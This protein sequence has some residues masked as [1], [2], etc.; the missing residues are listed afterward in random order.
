MDKCNQP[1]QIS[2]N[3]SNQPLT[4]INYL[5][6]NYFPLQ[7]NQQTVSNNQQQIAQ[8][9]KP[10]QILFQQN[11][12]KT[13][14]QQQ[15]TKMTKISTGIKRRPQ[16]YYGVSDRHD[17]SETIIKKVKFNDSGYN[18]IKPTDDA[19]I[20]NDQNGK[21]YLHMR[22]INQC[23]N[24]SMTP[25]ELIKS[26]VE[27]AAKLHTNSR[28][29]IR[30]SL[31]A[32]FNNLKPI[33][34]NIGLQFDNAKKLWQHFEQEYFKF[35]A[36]YKIKGYKSS[37]RSTEL[38]N[39]LIEKLKEYSEQ[40]PEI[41]DSILSFSINNLS[42]DESQYL[43]TQL[44]IKLGIY[45]I[46]IINQYKNGGQ[47]SKNN[48]L[49]ILIS[50]ATKNPKLIDAISQELLFTLK[51][52][53]GVKL[54]KEFKQIIYNNLLHDYIKDKDRA[55]IVELIN[56]THIKQIYFEL[57]QYESII[58]ICINDNR[59][60]DAIGIFNTIPKQCKTFELYNTILSNCNKLDRLD[61]NTIELL[62][63]MVEYVKK[64]DKDPRKYHKLKMPI[65]EICQ[66]N[67]QNQYMQKM[68]DDY[69]E[70]L[71]SQIRNLIDNNSLN[72]TE[73]KM[74]ELL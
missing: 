20:I 37:E 74:S 15:N 60:N 42:Y 56:Q 65:L 22:N 33:F 58:D 30:K 38:L 12:N 61:P 54:D 35:V 63:E 18:A 62:I 26:L 44:Q 24:G 55:K 67:K 66:K 70:L 27:I 73:Q 7:Q 2:I 11:M 34:D 57:N 32:E 17:C 46:D 16:T 69:N 10:Q 50:L 8:Q 41:I 4:Q 39:N 43:N 49:E 36:R 45:N 29:Y 14:K 40:V 59:L 25:E 72:A 3:Y 1:N 68:C 47:Y 9:Q 28:Y 13:L 19:N 53:D 51:Y 71:R 52:Y 6:N 5:Q 23:K 21:M 64:I 31:K 48:L